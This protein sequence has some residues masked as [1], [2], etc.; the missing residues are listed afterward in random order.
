MCVCVCGAKKRKIGQGLERQRVKGRKVG[1]KRD[2]EEIR[3]G[4]G[5]KGDVKGRNNTGDR[6]DQD[7][8][9]Q[10]DLD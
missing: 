4:R 2:K 10:G 3:E 6:E 5:T 8:T 1:G 7:K 9:R